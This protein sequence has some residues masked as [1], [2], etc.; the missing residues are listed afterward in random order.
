MVKNL[1]TRQE[2]WVR[3]LGWEDPLVKEVA[4]HSSILAWRVP[5]TEEPGR[6]QF[7]GSKEFYMTEQLTLH[8]YYGWA[9]SSWWRRSSEWGSDTGMYIMVE[10]PHFALIR[11]GRC[12]LWSIHNLG[13]LFEKKEYKIKYVSRTQNKY[14]F[15]TRKEIQE[16]FKCKEPGKH[17]KHQI[18]RSKILFLFINHPKCLY[19]VL[20]SF[21]YLSNSKKYT[22]LIW[23]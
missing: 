15:R 14:L 8:Y 23:N 11:Q 18:E 7:T 13:A 10:E 6:L 1:P 20:G 22:K 16:M 2:T 17:Y 4:T 9:W 3:S 21:L 12:T 5:W 19:N